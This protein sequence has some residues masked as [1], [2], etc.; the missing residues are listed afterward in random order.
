MLHAN[1]GMTTESSLI[2]L[3]IFRESINRVTH[4][5]SMAPY[6]VDLCVVSGLR[7]K[8]FKLRENRLKNLEVSDGFLKMRLRSSML[9]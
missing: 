1:W 3:N 2:F 7:L 5:L 8:G 6:S 4:E 9:A